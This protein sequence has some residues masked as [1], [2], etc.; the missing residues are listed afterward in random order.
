LFDRHEVQ[1]PSALLILEQD[2]EMDHNYYNEGLNSASWRSFR[3]TVWHTD[4]HKR[5]R[6]GGRKEPHRK[7][8]RYERG[9]DQLLPVVGEPERIVE[10]VRGGNFKVRVRYDKALRRFSTSKLRH[11]SRLLQPSL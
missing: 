9:R 3:M 1:L 5:K 8:R 4:V 10:R 7:R 2:E 6:T 11:P